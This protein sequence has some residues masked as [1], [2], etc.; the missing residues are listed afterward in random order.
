M[1][2][3]PKRIGGQWRVFDT[4][5]GGIAMNSRTGKPVDGGGHGSDEAK[6]LRQISYIT[7]V[8]KKPKK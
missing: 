1:A 4:E 5:T 8:G 6:A 3:I 2:L 7:G